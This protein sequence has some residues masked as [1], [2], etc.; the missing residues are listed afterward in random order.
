LYLPAE[1]AKLTRKFAFHFFFFIFAATFEQ[2]GRIINNY[3]PRFR[4]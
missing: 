1:T 2:K 4:A 3:S